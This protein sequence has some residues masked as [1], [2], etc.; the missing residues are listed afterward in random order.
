M[1]QNAVIPLEQSLRG[2]VIGRN[3]GDYDEARALYNGM[4]DKHPLVIA[5]CADIADVVAAVNFGRET[6]IRVAIRGGGHNGPGLAS[7]DDGLVIDLSTMKGVRVDPASKTVRVEAGCT[8]GDVDHATHPFGLAVPFGIVSTTGVAGLTLGGGLGYLS[9]K[10]GLTIDNL[11][12]A[13][14]VLASGEIVTASKSKNPD[15]FWALRGGG[16]NFGVVVSFL[17]QAH[18]AKTIYGGPVFWDFKHAREVMR[19]YRDFLP[20]AP[21]ELGVFVGLKTVLPVDPFPA[22]HRGKLA[23]GVIACFN[24]PG[25]RGAKAIARLLNGLP[26]PMFNWLGEM[27]FPAMQSLFDAFYPKGLQ[28]YWR[29]DFVKELTDEAIEAH[30]VQAAKSPSP[31]SMMHLYPIDG[32]VQRVGKSDTAWNT[33]DASLCM[34][35]CAVDADPQKAGDLSRWAKGYWDAI[36]PFSKSGGGYV[37]FMMDDG[38]EHRLKATY[39]ENYDRLVALKGKYDPAN[40]FSVNQNIKPNGPSVFRR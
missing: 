6:G 35:I 10:H 26:E 33:R 40:F 17:F 23:C 8:S 14:V 37:N 32:A 13:D 12:E 24:G 11:I 2:R 29:G 30:L 34:V 5:R 4:I 25:D 22:E 19:R 1:Q 27:P 36:H 38:D 28:W 9:R 31:R 21:E 18:P 7:V 3:D 39:G 16:G 15:L 20:N